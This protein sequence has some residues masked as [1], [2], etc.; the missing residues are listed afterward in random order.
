MLA[1][2]VMTAVRNKHH[3]VSMPSVEAGSSLNKM[4]CCLQMQFVPLCQ[5]MIPF[6]FDKLFVVKKSF[7][8]S[9]VSKLSKCGQ[10]DSD[11]FFYFIAR[12]GIIG[13]RHSNNNN[14]QIIKHI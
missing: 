8:F 12:A 6:G 4:Q 2:D 3:S 1:A 10:P 5:P 14:K 7:V 11:S 9:R 13:Q